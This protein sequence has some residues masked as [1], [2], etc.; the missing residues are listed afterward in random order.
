MLY[1]GLLY[2]IFLFI[3]FSNP[4]L[5]DFTYIMAAFGISYMTI[6]GAAQ[7][8]YKNNSDMIINSLPL[9]RHEIVLSKYLSVVVFT[10]ISL[11]MVGIVG[12]IFH[13]LPLPISYRLIKMTDVIITIISVLFLASISLPLY[14]KSWGG[15]WAR[16]FNVILFM[17]LF[18]AP[19]Q[20]SEY[21]VNN[22][23]QA[24][25]QTLSFL[26]REQMWLVSLLSMLVI[27]ILFLISF[28]IA[29]RIYIKRDF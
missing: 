4:M 27:L 29:Q 1:F 20:I 18:F 11:A 25:V 3:V 16:V 7:A 10:L 26:V 21:L 9:T 5:K 19:A 14:F 8:E 15:Q 6:I 2:S 22:N 23:Q 24:W 13:L 12:L 17:L 28:T